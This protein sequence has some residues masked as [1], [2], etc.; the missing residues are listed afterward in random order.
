M[1]AC[2]NG[3]QVVQCDELMRNVSMSSFDSV[4]M[5]NGTNDVL[6]WVPC[7]IGQLCVDEDNAANVV[8][9]SQFTYHVQERFLPGFW[10]LALVSCTLDD[11]C[12]WV[13][14]VGQIRLHYDI[15]L[16]NGSPLAKYMN[17]FEHQVHR[18]SGTR[19][20]SSVF[21]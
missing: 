5:S 7:P 15:W 3:A 6:R 20:N 17:P 10:Y 18:K 16:V 8:P 12:K 2:S 21:L 14:A 19:S 9:S 1:C 13:P 11:R 4:C